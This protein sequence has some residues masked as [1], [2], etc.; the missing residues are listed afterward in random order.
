MTG[1]NVLA[2]DFSPAV[3]GSGPGT[4]Q[5]VFRIPDK[6]PEGLYRIH[7]Q[8]IVNAMGRSS[9]FTC[10]TQRKGVP[11]SLVRAVT[12]AGESA[13]YQ[14]AVERGSAVSVFMPVTALIR[15]LNDSATVGF[16]PNDGEH[17]AS[18]GMNYVSPQR[19][20]Q[21][22]QEA[23]DFSTTARGNMLIRYRIGADGR[24]LEYAFEQQTRRISKRDLG[25]ARR[26]ISMMDFRPGFHQGNPVEMELGEIYHVLSRTSRHMSGLSAD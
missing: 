19:I 18:M 12:L 5:A 4:I 15:V 16:F 6:L 8:T 14:P 13:R 22:G 26:R 2:S 25:D 9:R 23:T 11:A 17:W 7:C 21:F 20:E 3:F 1:R 24:I 10:L